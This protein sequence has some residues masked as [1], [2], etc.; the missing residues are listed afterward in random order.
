M[1]NLLIVVYSKNGIPAA[2]FDFFENFGSPRTQED[3]YTM[4][5]IFILIHGK[6]Q[7]ELYVNNLPKSEN[8]QK[9]TYNSLALR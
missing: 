2:E 9:W 3:I 7:N 1:W 4:H 5:E 8:G 6:K